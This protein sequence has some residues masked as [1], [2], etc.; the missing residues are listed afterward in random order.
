MLRHFTPPVYN[1]TESGTQTFCA[2]MMKIR[3]Y[4]LSFSL[5]SGSAAEIKYDYWPRERTVFLNAFQPI[6]ERYRRRRRTGFYLMLAFM[7]FGFSLARVNIGDAAKLWGFILLLATWFA[8]IITL[9]FGQRLKCPA[10]RKRLEPAK[11]LYCPQCGSDEFQPG[12]RR[13]GSAGS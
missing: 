4:R 7:F 3:R 13:R 10:C 11:G 2:S 6:A 9:V 1:S 12:T 8:A 5:N